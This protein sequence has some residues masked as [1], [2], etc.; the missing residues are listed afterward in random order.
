MPDFTVDPN[1]RSMQGPTAG[2]PPNPFNG[3]VYFDIDLG[4]ASVWNGTRWCPVG[5]S[6]AF[7][8]EIQLIAASDAGPGRLFYN[9]EDNNL[10]I[11]D[12][13]AWLETFQEDNEESSSS[14]STSSNSSSSTSSESSSS[15]SSSS[16]ESSSST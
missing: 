16:T 6:S 12:G 7:I 5:V 1:G 9:T 3:S 11:S 15:S 4:I 10:I 13:A 8:D 14:T 2:R